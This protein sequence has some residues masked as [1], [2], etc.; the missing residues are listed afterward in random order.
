M[1][2]AQGWHAKSWSVPHFYVSKVQIF[3]YLKKVFFQI[4]K[5]NRNKKIGDAGDRTRG[6]IHAKHA[7]Y[8]WA[9]SPIDIFLNNLHSNSKR[10]KDICIQKFVFFFLNFAFIQVN[11]MLLVQFY[12][13]STHSHR[14]LYSSVAEHWSCKPGVLSSIL[15][16]GIAFFDFF[17]LC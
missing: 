11:C 17:S 8:H 2:P 9:T 4:H 13:S 7:L 6:L 14:S 3:Y 16:G 15:S 12:L 5:K 10:V 1:A